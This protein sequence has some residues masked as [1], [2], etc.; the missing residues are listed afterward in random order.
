MRW[1]PKLL[2][3]GLLWAG[4]GCSWDVVLEDNAPHGGDAAVER[5]GPLD[6]PDEDGIS[7]YDEGDQ[8]PDGDGLPNWRDPDSDGDGISDQ[9]ESGDGDCD[10]PPIDSDLDSIADFVDL[11]SDSDWISDA[12]EGSEDADGDSLPAYLDRDSDADGVSDAEE[13]GD[14]SL[15]T[16]AAEC[17]AEVDPATG[18][19][20]RD[21]VPDYLDPDSD[22][23]GLSDADE[24][25]LGTSPCSTDTDGDGES[26]ITEGAYEQLNCTSSTPAACGCASDP[27]CGIPEEHISVV[28]PFGGAPVARDLRF[29]TRVRG[30]DVAVLAED[31]AGT[32]GSLHVL[33]E[34]LQDPTEGVFALVQD[35]LSESQFSLVTYTDFPFAP[36]GASTDLP[37]RMLL[38]MSPA[39]PGAAPWLALQ[40][41]IAEM[42]VGQG[43]DQATSATEALYQILTGDGG[44]YARGAALFEWPAFRDRCPDSSWGAACFREGTRPV[45]VHHMKSCAHDG[46]EAGAGAGCEP[47]TGLV[48]RSRRWDE[49]LTRLGRVGARYI[50]LHA[51]PLAC[52]GASPPRACRYI[53]QTGRL[54]G[55]LNEAGQ[56]YLMQM[57]ETMGAWSSSAAAIADAI[58]RLGSQTPFDVDTVARDDTTDEYEVDARR[59]L[60]SRQPACEAVPPLDPCWTG[61]PGSGGGAAVGGT[62]ASTFF[63]VI[64]GTQVIFRLRFENRFLEG[65]S[66]VRVFTAYVDI[67]GDEVLRLQTRQVYV[68]VP[69]SSSRI[70]I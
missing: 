63:S 70:V 55:S 21:G 24:A 10:T 64:P 68:V 41:A 30:V 66:A 9:D 47:Y 11:D 36:Y 20:E 49:T 37:M 3:A 17:L 51:G 34:M 29:D 69:A 61:T 2:L 38:N 65:G 27:L 54:T 50:G 35:R 53:E 7:S 44:R 25:A 19:R 67:R 22:N 28:L 46:P 8:D 31:T 62:D 48:P 59:F 4:G 12:E 40:D 56:S 39:P 58:I 43:G 5:C 60:L 1:G 26:D 18:R 6:D 15:E 42:G 16:P 52:T 13:A 32:R 45:L 33:G 23:D 14:E 57:P